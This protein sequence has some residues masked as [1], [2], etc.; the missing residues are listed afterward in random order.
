MIHSP[1]AGGAIPWTH[2]RPR[3][4]GGPH[5]R[6]GARDHPQVQ[7]RA[8]R[9]LPHRAAQIPRQD[10]RRRRRANH[11]DVKRAAKLIIAWDLLILF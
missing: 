6:G 1:A 8:R 2:T 4:E 3:V 5:A 10:R 7:G 11:G 9:A